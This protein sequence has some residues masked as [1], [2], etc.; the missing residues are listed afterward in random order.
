MRCTE[1]HVLSNPSHPLSTP[2]HRR[3]SLTYLTD[4]H[5]LLTQVPLTISPFL[6][7]P[8]S[9]PLPYSYKSLPSTLPPSITSESA[10]VTSA[11]G[12]SAHPDTILSSCTALQQHLSKLEAEARRTL[13]GWE[14]KRAAEDLAEK[15]RLAPGWLDSGVH[16]LKPEEEEK[17]DKGIV[18]N[19]MD[20]D[21]QQREAETKKVREGEELDR[22]F[23]GLKV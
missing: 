19:I 21:P 10:Y 1:S 6:S 5:P 4:P 14:D 20:D 16:I 3:P 8:T 23:G 22:V 9:V 12:S 2:Q 13:K 18:E 7:L 17:K 15:R 11:S